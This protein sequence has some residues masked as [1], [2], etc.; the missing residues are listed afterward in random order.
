MCLHAQGEES[1]VFSFVYVC[2][3]LL[4]FC[5]ILIFVSMQCL[6]A[7]TEVVWLLPFTRQ[8]AKDKSGRRF[9]CEKGLVA[10]EHGENHALR[11]L[12]FSP[13]ECKTSEL[14]V[15]SFHFIWLEDCFFP[16]PQTYPRAQQHQELCVLARLTPV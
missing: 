13:G 6:E 5:Y 4:Y 12:F 8:M 7:I 1:F 3:L 10:L 14:R 15:R 16:A 11:K 9:W 2:L